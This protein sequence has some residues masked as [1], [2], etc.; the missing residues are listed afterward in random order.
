LNP[1]QSIT[2]IAHQLGFSDAAHFC[3]VFTRFQ[4]RSPRAY[5]HRYAVR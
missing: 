5:R 1:A 4:H 2:E 3:R